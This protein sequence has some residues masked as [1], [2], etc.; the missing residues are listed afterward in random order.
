MEGRILAREEAIGGH[1]R[2]EWRVQRQ[3]QEDANEKM[4]ESHC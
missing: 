3:T 2:G 1:G 4:K